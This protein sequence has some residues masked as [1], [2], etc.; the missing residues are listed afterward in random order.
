MDLMVESKRV[1]QVV[2]SIAVDRDKSEI[3]EEVPIRASMWHQ[4]AAGFS[5]LDRVRDLSGAPNI[6]FGGPNK[7]LLYT[8]C[9]DGAH[10]RSQRHNV[11]T[12]VSHEARSGSLATGIRL[13]L[14]HRR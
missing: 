3:S 8:C 11:V 2:F 13:C 14:V 4:V 12:C 6:N 9:P 5:I 7:P 10:T 1:R